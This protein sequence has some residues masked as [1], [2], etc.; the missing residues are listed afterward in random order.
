M[1]H[2]RSLLR[3]IFLQDNKGLDFIMQSEY[4]HDAQV[5]GGGDAA[6]VPGALIKELPALKEAVNLY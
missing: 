1:M 2:L 4:A 5:R 3:D 6:I